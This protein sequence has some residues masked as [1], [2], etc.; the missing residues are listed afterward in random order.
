MGSSFSYF[1]ESDLSRY[2]GEWIA[3]LGDDVVAH[4]KDAK[5]VYDDFKSK[6]PDRTPF[7]TAV[8]K[9]AAIL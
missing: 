6:H 8:P 7:L 2:A 9:A 1:L 5:A 4:G 3:L